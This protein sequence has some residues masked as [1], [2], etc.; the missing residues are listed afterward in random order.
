[1]SYQVPFTLNNLITVEYDFNNISTYIYKITGN[2]KAYNN[3]IFQYKNVVKDIELIKSL[4]MQFITTIYNETNN[5]MMYKKI[6]EAGNNLSI[7]FIDIENNI[8]YDNGEVIFWD[9]IT[10]EQRQR[11]ANRKTITE[12]AKWMGLIGMFNQSVRDNYTTTDDIK[13]RKAELD[14]YY[15]ELNYNNT[16]LKN[17]TFMMLDKKAQNAYR[18]T[19][20]NI[21]RP[22]SA[23]YL[24]YELYGEYIDDEVKLNNF[25]NIL[26]GLNRSQPAHAMQGLLNIIEV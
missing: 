14:T 5:Y 4:Y 25:A 17:N 6:T 7:E 10:V 26:V 1:M 11:S 18:V 3:F 24:A 16:M 8:V 19:T 22:Y 9:D 12:I 13:K 21:T 2:K 23:K 20:I 15:Q